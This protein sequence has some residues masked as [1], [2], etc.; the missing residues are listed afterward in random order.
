LWKGLPV[1]TVFFV[2][3]NNAVQYRSNVKWAALYSDNSDK[4]ILF[5]GMLIF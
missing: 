3:R 5:A 1:L 4:V 2:V